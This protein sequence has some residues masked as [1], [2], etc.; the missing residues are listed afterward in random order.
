[1]D[2]GVRVTAV[3]PSFVTTEMTEGLPLKGMPMVDPN[4]VAA[5]ILRAVRRGGP[6]LVPVPRWM[7]GIPRMAAFTPQAGLDW[8]RHGFGE[9]DLSDPNDSRQRYQER[10]RR[11]LLRPDE[12]GA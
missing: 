12:G 11:L 10:L 8:M 1:H 4:V 3:L 2:S 6:A 5:A 7:G 9:R